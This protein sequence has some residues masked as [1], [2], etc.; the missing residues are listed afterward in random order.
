ML[1]RELLSIRSQLQIRGANSLGGGTLRA[2]LHP[3]S[4]GHNNSTSQ[5][6]L[7]KPGDALFSHHPVPAKENVGSFGATSQTGLQNNMPLQYHQQQPLL[8]DSKGRTATF[9]YPLQQQNINIVSSSDIESGYHQQITS[10]DKNQRILISG[11]L[12][13]KMREHQEN[14][15]PN[16]RHKLSQHNQSTHSLQYRAPAAFEDEDEDL[17]YQDQNYQQKPLSSRNHYSQKKQALSQVARYKEEL[18]SLNDEEDSMSS[19]LDKPGSQ[20][21]DRLNQVKNVFS[22]IKRNLEDDHHQQHTS[23]LDITDHSQQ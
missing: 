10:N 23:S 11:G 9:E 22:A 6:H 5:L 12:S 18:D 13:D 14:I 16:Y 1:E 17:M 15:E 20:F 8:T 7:L 19:R 3:S 2:P 4:M 21:Q